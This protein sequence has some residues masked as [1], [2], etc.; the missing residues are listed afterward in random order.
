TATR[1]VASSPLAPVVP[2]TFLSFFFSSRRRHTRSKRDWS[3]DVC[4]S[5]LEASGSPLISSFP[6]KLISTLPL[7]CGAEIK[8]SCF[9]AVTPRSEERRVG[10][11][12]SGR[13]CGDSNTEVD[14]YASESATDV[15]HADE[16]RS[17]TSD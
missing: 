17:A 9:S 13:E 1:I 8:E 15:R 4:S 11:E 14:V 10:K 16:E 7:G 3:S 2:L 6:E 5:D 12:E